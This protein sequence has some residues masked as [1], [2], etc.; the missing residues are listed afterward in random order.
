MSIDGQV[1]CWETWTVWNIFESLHLI[2]YFLS[3]LSVAKVM[4]KQRNRVSP[5]SIGIFQHVVVRVSVW[6]FEQC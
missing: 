3:E 4:T 1:T 6:D 2:V 5:V